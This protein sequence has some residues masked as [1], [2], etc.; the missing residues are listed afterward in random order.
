MVLSGCRFDLPAPP[1]TPPVIPSLVSVTRSTISMP[2]TINVDELKANLLQDLRSKPLFEGK[3][4]EIGAKLL[5]EEKTI[6][7]E[8]RKIIDAPYK[9]AECQVKRI[10][11]TITK[12][13]KVGVEAYGCWLQP[14]KWGNCFKDVFKNVTETIWEEATEC[15]PEQLEIARIIYTPVEKIAEKILDT[16]VVLKYR[17]DLTDMSLNVV[18]NTISTRIA[19]DVPVSA[20]IKANTLV[21]NITAKGVLACSSHIEVDGNIAFDVVQIGADVVLKAK[22]QGLETE[23]KKFCIP[24]AVQL[25]QTWSYT[26]LEAFA[27]SRL[28]ASVFEKQLTAAANKAVAKAAGD[29]PIQR[30]LSETVNKLDAPVKIGTELWLD[31]VPAKVLLSQIAGNVDSGSQTLMLTAGIEADLSVIYGAKP[32]SRTP[33]QIPVSLGAS[34]DAFHLVPRGKAFVTNLRAIIESA[35]RSEYGDQLKGAGFSLDGVKAYQ[36]GKSIVFGITIKGTKLFRPT[37]TIYLSGEPRYDLARGGMVFDNF[38]FTLETKNWLVK[39]VAAIGHD[40]VVKT[41]ADKAVIKIDEQLNHF[42]EQFRAFEVP[43]AGGSIT[44][45]VTSAKI[46]GFW[47]EGDALNFDLVL[48]GVSRLTLRK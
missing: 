48:D 24:G 37:G 21:G 28:V 40:A 3:S 4:P 45:K 11:K 38:D 16:S 2:I 43:T 19:F 46:S 5:A 18:G 42:L 47:M 39:N 14:W 6:F 17:G 7:Q 36:S 31:V 9:A 8:P 34:G 22:V 29:L 1:P 15:V 26:S 41:L 23:I 10:P 20:D 32:L 30:L 12:S 35:L 13:V 44:G 33:R 25:A 27:M